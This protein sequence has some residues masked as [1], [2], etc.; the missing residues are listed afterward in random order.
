RLLDHFPNLRIGIT[1][2]I[3]FATNANTSAVIQ[4]MVS[5]SSGP[6]RILLETDAPYMVPANLYESLEG[7]KGKLPLCHT[8]MVPW[9]AEFVAKVAGEAWTADR[10]MQEAR[11][12]AR[13]V[14]G[15]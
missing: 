10:V 8:A 9:T 12:S 11:E 1:G 2:V 7:M 3:T 13:H 14:Y 15:V 6:L 5:Q 4:N